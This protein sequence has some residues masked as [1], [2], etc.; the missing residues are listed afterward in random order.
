MTREPTK[1]SMPEIVAEADAVAKDAQRTFGHLNANQINWKPSTEQWSIGQCFEHLINANQEYFPQLNQVIRGQKKISL[2]QRMPFLPGFFGKL[3][4]KSL[5]PD[6]KRKLKAPKLFQP[7]L[8]KIDPQVIGKFVAHQN[9]LMA[10]MK[11]IEGEDLEKII[12]YSPVSKMVI[13]SLLDACRII[14]VH[15][16]RHFRQ[17]QRVMEAS[18]FPK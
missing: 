8:S 18:G 3:L 1:L 7:A 14:V 16:R 11:A 6:S 5:S 13:Y 10:K 4:V 9:D 15:E 2:W 17:A 12:I